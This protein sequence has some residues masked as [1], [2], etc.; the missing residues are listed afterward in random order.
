MSD[1]QKVLM[2]LEEEKKKNK[3]LQELTEY[4][5][6]KIY[7]LNN[8]IKELEKQVVEFGYLLS[9]CVEER[10]ENTNK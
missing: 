7:K 2:K 10:N 5:E 8:K 3:E 1:Y 9:N 4:Y 6:R